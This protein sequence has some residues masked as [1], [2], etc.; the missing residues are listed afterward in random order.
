VTTN[1]SGTSTG[2]IKYF[3]FGDCRNSS[4]SLPPQKFTGQRLDSTGLY[5][6]G[7][8]YY[9]PVIGR[10]ISPDT[11]V[12]SPSNP[13][14][15]NRYSYCL[16]NPLKYIDPS[17]H[18]VAWVYD[19]HYEETVAAW[20]RYKEV[21]YETAILMEQ[22]DEL[23]SIGGGSLNGDLGLTSKNLK[24]GLQSDGS[25][26]FNSNTRVTIDYDMIN[27]KRNEGI[28]AVVTVLAHEAV[29]CSIIAEA[30][31]NNVSL[32][33][34]KST[35]YEETI[36]LQH[37]YEVGQKLGY[38]AGPGW[39]FWEIFSPSPMQRI[40]SLARNATSIDL[41]KHPEINAAYFRAQMH[42]AYWSSAY[43]GLDDL[44]DARYFGI[45]NNI[46]GM[47]D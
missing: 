42:Q 37:Q 6:Y 12:P 45:M 27:S 19:D 35:Q 10:F 28:D 22:S 32:N 29:H 21:N 5:Y 46:I 36:A 34:M 16:N 39:R 15:L 33:Y 18:Y 17:G 41:S 25:Y 8:R 30:I 38:S 9:D 43:V 44:P 14:S 3:S 23:F 24:P 2:S 11:I 13:Q 31:K 26:D 4:G 20:N 47:I 7:A 40:N 1:S